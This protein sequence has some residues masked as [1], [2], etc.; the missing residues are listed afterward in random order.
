MD[1]NIFQRF[2]KIGDQIMNELDL[3]TLLNCTLV[4]KG[5]Y[6]FLNDPFF[7]LKKLKDVAQPTEIEA[8]WKN[9]IEKSVQIGVDKRVFAICLKKK[10]QHFVES[11]SKDVF[12]GCVEKNFTLPLNKCLLHSEATYII[13]VMK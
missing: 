1:T 2:P 4:C 13:G 5:W 8:Y 9:L 12:T 11:E 7:W 3:P 6:S 10:F